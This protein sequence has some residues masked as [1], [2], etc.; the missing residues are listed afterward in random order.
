MFGVKGRP[1][2]PDRG[3]DPKSRT[4]NLGPYTAKGCYIGNLLKASTF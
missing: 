3:E 4:P 1:G 2:D